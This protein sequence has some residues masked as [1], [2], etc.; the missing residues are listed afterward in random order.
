MQLQCFFCYLCPSALL[1]L[2]RPFWNIQLNTKCGVFNTNPICSPVT[3]GFSTFFSLLLASAIS[4]KN[5]DRFIFRSRKL[6][7][8][9]RQSYT[10]AQKTMDIVFLIITTS[11]IPQAIGYGGPLLITSRLD[12]CTEGLLV[13]AKDSESASL[14]NHLQKSVTKEGES[15]VKKHYRALSLKPPPTGT[16]IPFLLHKGRP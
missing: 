12:H 2:T 10:L 15:C 7:W 16:F 6:F 3:K 11:F 9:S 5:L 8:S 1:F 4:T 14:Y 13:L